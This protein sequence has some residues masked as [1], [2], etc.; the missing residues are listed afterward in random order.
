MAKLHEV[1]AVEGELEGTAKRILKETEN[2]FEKKVSHFSGGIKTYQAFAESDNDKALAETMAEH[3]EIV[4]TVP[5]KL[6]YMWGSVI[7][8]LDVSFQKEKTNCVATGNIEVDGTV[9]VA[10]VP[11]GYLLGLE[12]KIATWKQVL[13]KIPTL[14][15][16]VKWEKDEGQGADVYKRT[17]DEK[18]TKTKKKLVWQEVA[19]PDGKNPAQVEKWN[20]DV[21][22]G[23]YTTVVWQ[24]MLTVADKS[25]MLN[26][27][28]K[29]G[30]AVKKARMRANQKDVVDASIG[31]ALINYIKG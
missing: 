21:P 25:A 29:L 20:E 8:H 1:L 26:R 18:T 11:V 17:I 3:K 24:S 19:A 14:A 13:N 15:P 10:D 23:I 2:T 9:I 22:V 31:N 6:E 28:D 30:Q 4:E 12:K 27:L 7:D 5:S 16:G